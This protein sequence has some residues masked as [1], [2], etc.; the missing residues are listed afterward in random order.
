MTVIKNNSMDS[1]TVFVKYPVNDT[2]LPEKN[3][4]LRLIN[5]NSKYRHS[6]GITTKKNPIKGKIILYFFRSD[7]ISKNGWDYIRNK[8][9]YIKKFET[10]SI[11]ISKNNGLV[12]YP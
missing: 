12:S 5:P 6:L 8:N 11:E 1:V 4:Y 10:S 2:L 9:L 3:P 7:E